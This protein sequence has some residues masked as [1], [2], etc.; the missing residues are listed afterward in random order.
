LVGFF[1]VNI[2][3]TTAF[4]FL[5]CFLFSTTYFCREYVT[6]TRCL[7]RQSRPCM[8]DD[9]SAAEFLHAT[10][11][12]RLAANADETSSS[13]ASSSSGGGGSAGGGGYSSSHASRPVAA[14]VLELLSSVLVR[15]APG[16]PN[17]TAPV[18]VESHAVY[19]VHRLLQTQ[20][21]K[22]GRPLVFRW[23]RLWKGLM[24]TL[25]RCSASPEA[26]G[27]PHVATLA[28]QAMNLISFC[29]VHRWGCT[30]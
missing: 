8:S 29:L 18:T 21:A 19:V 13:S 26:M 23:E 1:T 28:A 2:T 7:S 9:K 25:A 11:I 12:S 24:R 17:A 22:G 6:L 16:T 3:T 14:A 20:V 5:F 27:L 4:C 30:K 15:G 10:D